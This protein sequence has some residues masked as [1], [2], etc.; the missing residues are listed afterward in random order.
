MWYTKVY[1]LDF[2]GLNNL[3]GSQMRKMVLSITVIA[4]LFTGCGDFIGWGGENN[5]VLPGNFWAQ[6]LVTGAFYRIDAE[7]L[8]ENSM[9]EVWA[10][11]GSGV[12]AAM[13]NN[14]V[15]AYNTVYPKMMK[16]FGFQV[17][18]K[19][20]GKKMNTMEIAHWLATGKTSGAKLTILFLDVKDGYVKEGDFYYGGYFY[21][22]D[23]F[24]NADY[25][26]FKSNE[27][28]MI[29]FD[30]YPSTY[31]SLL[32]LNA[33]I[34]HL[35]HEMQHLMN[36]LSSYVIRGNNDNTDAWINEGLSEAAEWVC[37]GYTYAGYNYNIDRSGLI[38]KGNNF[39]V[40]NN[41]GA[42]SPWANYDDYVTASL[43]FQ[44]L[45]LQS[46]NTD[47]YY[48]IH[49]S[50]FSNYQAVTS[51]ANSKIDS[52]YNNNWPLLLRDWHAAN[53]TNDSSGRYGYMNDSDL[54]NVKAKM[55]PTTATSVNLFPGEGVYSRTTTDGAV[56]GASGA[57]RYAGLPPVSGT[58]SD[59]ASFA[60]GARL[61]Y[62]VNT[63]AKGASASGNTTGIAPSVGI[64]TPG[65]SG[66]VQIEANKFSDPFKVDAGYFHLENGGIRDNEIRSLFNNNDGIVIFDISTLERVFIDE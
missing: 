23:L 8:T 17:D 2:K 20:V 57:I 1:P 37:S 44:W 52:I 54:K 46:G 22:G 12:T 26:Q 19:N 33:Y 51:A 65:G 59:T 24:K 43:F 13:A 15:N 47:I 41:R 60:N 4:L 35:A 30:T 56:P 32:G 31:P 61:T 21:S 38:A 48:D 11:K 29:Y 63:N 28:A 53:F 50:K 25:P 5:T 62:N 45:R 27:R 55:F 7:K 64:S 16:T 9:C 42:E 14:A 10:E 58:P 49:T 36:F 18:V 40:W 3:G 39:Y 6:N 34:P 66:S